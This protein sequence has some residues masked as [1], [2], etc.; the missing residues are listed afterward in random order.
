MSFLIKFW[1]A[2]LMPLAQ[3]WQSLLT[4]LIAIVAVYI[5]WQQWKANE[6]K[7][8]LE[9]YNHRLRIYEEVKKILTLMYRDADVKLNDLLEFNA[10][11]AEAD[12]LFGREIRQYIDEIFRGDKLSVANGK[13]RH[14][15]QGMPPPD[16]YD[17][18]QVVQ[19]MN[20]QLTWL[21]EQITLVEGRLAVTEKFKPYLDISK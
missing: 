21:T 19:E 20:S 17:H 14:V 18:N 6:L 13:Y 2:V 5:A 12:F 11:V 15:T 1:E 16:G 4:P 10:A 8:R 9:R 7:L 3:F